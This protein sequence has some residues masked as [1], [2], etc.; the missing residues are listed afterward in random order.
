MKA[1]HALD[2]QEKSTPIAQMEENV[3]KH[4]FN[5]MNPSV[6][7]SLFMGESVSFSFACSN[8]MSQ[9]NTNT[10]AEFCINRCQCWRVLH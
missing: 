1:I 10:D 5:M 4:R 9:Q 8:F 3:M 7:A 2:E 6:H